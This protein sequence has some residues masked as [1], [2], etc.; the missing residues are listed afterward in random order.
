MLCVLIY[1]RTNCGLRSVITII[2]A[3]R[4][5]F[6]PAMGRVPSYNS[7][8]NWVRKL[9]LSVY[10]DAQPRGEAHAQ[11][12]DESIAL[13]K[14]KLLLI[15]GIK[16][17][18]D[19]KP[20]GHKDVTVLGMRVGESFT[21]KE[22]KEE[23]EK[24]SAKAGAPPEYGISDG[25]HNLAGGFAD[26]GVTQHLD[27]SHTLGNCMK[28]AY[29]KDPEFLAL[30]EE[31]N[32]IRV[33]Y[34]LTEKAWLL[35]PKM[36][37]ISRFMNLH[38]WVDWAERLLGC[39]HTLD[40]GMKEAYSFILPYRSLVAELGVCVKA[41]RHVEKICKCEGF[42]HRTYALCRQHIIRNVI[43][44]ANSRRAAAGLEMV[45]YFDR[46]AALLADSGDVRHISSDIIESDFGIF[47]AKKSPNKLYGITSLVL[48]LPLYPKIADSSCVGTFAFKSR[49]ANV[50]LKD[51]DA[52][53][54]DNLPPNPVTIR[55]RTLQNAS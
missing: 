32:K 37:A 55:T 13:N 23:I 45:A 17:A 19:G 7:V 9:G 3:V 53:A 34:H 36:R 20:L 51:I 42:G 12:I 46:Q 54:K 33:K 5:V 21:R 6:G 11:I 38:Q 41:I 18:H 15:L 10:E 4:D 25:A 31:L 39:Y 49:L 35:P 40:D 16:A 8:A 14:H 1:L 43:G 28:H 2:G 30:T 24:A 52:W 26:A 48:M 47:K 29:G 22:V 44:N 50:K 27:I